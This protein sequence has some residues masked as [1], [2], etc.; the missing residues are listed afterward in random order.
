MTFNCF[1]LIIINRISKMFPFKFYWT[2]I[3]HKNQNLSR[4]KQEE[5][6]EEEIKLVEAQDIYGGVPLGLSDR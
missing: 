2:S 5:E 1:F 4:D 3:F 6:E